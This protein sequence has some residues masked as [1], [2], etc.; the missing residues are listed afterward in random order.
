M[1]QL[2]EAEP[3]TDSEAFQDSLPKYAA[4]G[5]QTLCEART[6]GSMSSYPLIQPRAGLSAKV[7]HLLLERLLAMSLGREAKLQHDALHSQQ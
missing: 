4:C 3:G 7:H 2:L 6:F 1:L 5:R